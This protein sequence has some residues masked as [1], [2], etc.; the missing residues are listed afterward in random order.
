MPPLMRVTGPPEGPMAIMRSRRESRPRDLFPLPLPGPESEDPDG[1]NQFCRAVRRRA[2][3]RRHRSSAAGDCVAA[4]NL[5]HNGSWSSD[6]PTRSELSLAQRTALAHVQACV[7]GVGKPPPLTPAGALTEL[8]GSPG[9]TGA[10]L[11]D[12]TVVPLDINRLS[13]PAEGHRPLGLG[14]LWGGPAG[15]KWVE[16]F[17]QRCDAKRSAFGLPVLGREF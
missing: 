14:E 5:L 3:A 12:C 11:S 13:L 15:R 2:H 4:L 9:Y 6:Q 8:C 7:R 10:E 17:C 1:G 16:E